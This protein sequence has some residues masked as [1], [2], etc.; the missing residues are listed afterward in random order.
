MAQFIS[1]LLLCACVVIQAYRIRSLRS[2][3]EDTQRVIGHM[4][5]GHITKVRETEDGGFEIIAE[6]DEQ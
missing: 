3:L 6:E 4:L 2:A 5:L 1:Y